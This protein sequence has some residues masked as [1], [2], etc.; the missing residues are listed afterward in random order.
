MYEVL[1]ELNEIVYIAD[2]HTYELLFLNDAGKQFFQID[3]DAPSNKCYAV[4]QGRDAPCPF[5]TNSKLSVDSVYE[6]EYT[7]PLTN[8]YYLLRDKLIHWADGRLVRM[9]IALDITKQITR[10]HEIEKMAE[11]ESFL[12]DS[13]KLL[14]RDR[15]IQRNIEDLLGEAGRFL[16]ADRMFILEFNEQQQRLVPLY[17]WCNTGISS[18]QEVLSE[19]PAEVFQKWRTYFHKNDFTYSTDTSELQKTGSSES[20]V[21]KKLGIT[22]LLSVPLMQGNGAVIGVFGAENVRFHSTP[23]N[24]KLLFK[25]FAFFVTEMFLRQKYE[26]EMT[27]RSFSDDLTGLQNRNKFMQDM[28]VLQREQT[29][30]VGIAFA[31]MNGLKQINDHHGHDA[32]DAALKKAAGRF[33]SLFR[34]HNLYRIGG[35]EFVIVCPEIPQHVFAQKIAALMDT[36]G[37]ESGH[38]FALGW[39]WFEQVSDI[40]THLK[41]T[42]AL[43]YRNKQAYYDGARAAE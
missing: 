43:M 14:H 35:D 29:R 9:E 23:Q 40:N 27:T 21:F 31:D 10:L 18:G 37:C 25:T 7:N 8:H 11:L 34:K 5:C 22:N 2:L 17:E 30:S 12:L 24:M 1:N 6:W 38:S 19:I 28:Q 3:N 41:D 32:G 26:S 15:D 33:L 36:A 4:L 20:A 42:D 16:Q 39:Q 13:I